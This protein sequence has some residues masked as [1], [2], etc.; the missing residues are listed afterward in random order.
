M[1]HIFHQQ[2]ILFYIIT[3]KL[4][5]NNAVPNTIVFIGVTPGYIW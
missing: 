1:Q 3:R 2:D 4:F 5:R